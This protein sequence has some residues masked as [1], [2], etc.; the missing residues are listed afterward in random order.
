M[1]NNI[2]LTSPLRL[3]IPIIK[4]VGDFCNLRC[5]YCFYNGKDQQRMT[6]M[7]PELLEKFIRQYL[8][9]FNGDVTFIWHGG[10]PLMAGINFFRRL[11]ALQNKHSAKREVKNCIQ[12]NATLIGTKWAQFFEQNHFG[13]GVSI[14]GRRDCHDRFRLS[15]HDTGTFDRAMLGVKALQAHGLRPGVIQTLTTSNLPF[16]KSNFD[17]FYNDMGARSWSTNIFKDLAGSNQ[18][19]AK[20]NVSNE[21]SSEFFREQLDLWLSANNPLLRIREIE[22]FISPTFSRKAPSCQFNGSC[23]GYFCLNYDGK[24][25]PCDRLSDDPRFL[26]GD[27]SQQNL[28]DILNGEARLTYAR[29]VNK[30]DQECAKCRWLSFCNNGCTGHRIGGPEGKYFFCESR[31]DSFLHVEKRMQSFSA[32]ERR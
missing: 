14:D 26:L 17:F 31:R 9:L 30:V 27:L 1:K 2:T 21:E 18:R 11:V 24:V 22:N 16:T 29:E 32:C 4:V 19:M 12:T 23:T 10:E 20:E 28:A 3:M 13:V 8:E 5:G 6:I 7:H 15:G 25:Y